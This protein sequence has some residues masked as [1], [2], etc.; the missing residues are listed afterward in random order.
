MPRRRKIVINKTIE[1]EWVEKFKSLNPKEVLKERVKE[2]SKLASQVERVVRESE[3]LYKEHRINSKDLMSM[4]LLPVQKAYEY[5]RSRGYEISF[6]A[7]GGR[8]ERGSIPSVKFGRKRYVPV[9][10]LEDLLNLDTKFYTVRKAYEVYKKYEPNIT[11]RAF[12]GRVEKGTLPSIKLG[13]RRLIPKEALDALT[14]VAK[15]YYTISQAM[16]VLR[17]NGI[18]IRRNAFER[19]IDRG[20]IPHVKI[21]GRRFIHKDVLNELIEKEKALKK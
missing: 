12:I 3:K 19:R 7:F 13:S 16:K 18:K 21:G 20:R 10:F 9:Q 6:R 15:N 14:H 8:I 5:L 11:F 4:G 17:K 2:Y 1:D